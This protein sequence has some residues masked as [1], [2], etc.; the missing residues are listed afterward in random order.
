MKSVKFY[1]NGSEF[2]RTNEPYLEIVFG[3]ID[4]NVG[5]SVMTMKIS[6]FNQ[7]WE[8]IKAI[9]ILQLLEIIRQT[10]MII[11]HILDLI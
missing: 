11:K 1:K 7:N 5:P 2:L 10:F 3:G 6:S 9:Y 8:H 4:K